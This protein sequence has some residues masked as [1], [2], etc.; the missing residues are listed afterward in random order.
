ME[1]PYNDFLIPHPVPVED[2]SIPEEDILNYEQGLSPSPPLGSWHDFTLKFDPT[3]QDSRTTIT[4]NDIAVGIGREAL[5]NSSTPDDEL[6]DM[7]KRM[8]IFLRGIQTLQGG[9]IEFLHI[10]GILATR[11]S[12]KL[13]FCMNQVFSWSENTG[14]YGTPF[15]SQE[16]GEL[17]LLAF[18]S[19]L[20][21]FGR[22]F[23]KASSETECI[24]Q[25]S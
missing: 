20:L 21:V 3:S 16:H 2:T 15:T 17:Q 22:L 5:W 23:Y 7:L 11:S 9:E 8:V 18:T 12:N 19:P 25:H 4:V 13:T 1:D 6:H 24:Q 10:S 14:T